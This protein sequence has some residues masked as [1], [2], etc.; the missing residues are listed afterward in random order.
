MAEAAGASLSVTPIEWNVVGLDS[1]TPATGPHAFSVGAQVCNTGSTTIPDVATTWVWDTSSTAISLTGA[2]V[3]PSV[4]LAPAACQ[5]FWYAVDVVALAS[6]FDKIRGFH[7]VA[8]GTGALSVSTPTPREIYV[9]HL[10]SQNRNAIT[11]VSG[12]TA[13]LVGNTYTYTVSG[14]TAPGGYGQLVASPFFDPSIF[15]VRSVSETMSVGGPSTTFYTDACGW[16]T[17]PTS[18]SYR[19]CTT[20]AD[21]GGTFTA[22][23]TATV[24]GTGTTTVRSVI[25]DFS[26]SSYHYN[27]DFGD[28]INAITVTATDPPVNG[29]PVA[30]DDSLTVAQDSLG[31]SVTVLGNDSDPDSDP[32][33]VSAVTQGG[34]GAVS[35]NLDGSVSYV[36]AAGYSGADSFTYTVSDGN[37]GF[38]TATVSVTVTPTPPPVPPTPTPTPTPAPAPT[39]SS[40]P[41]ADVEGSVAGNGPALAA[42]KTP[43]AV[44]RIR[45]SLPH[46]GATS[47]A[48]LAESALL[49][50]LVGSIVL[51][52]GTRRRVRGR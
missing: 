9:E 46:T 19:S 10:V 34:H 31:G 35:I 11:G 40:A 20:S 21:A 48:S 52:A 22:T 6:S 43:R 18:G 33:T 45:S 30:G 37:G 51:V 13:V 17:D 2:A 44:V 42:H 1:N 39:V 32:L 14:K 23:V 27:S 3:K 25:Y 47:S 4:S 36:P 26:G 8:S 28:A 49:L 41:A 29:D 12:P 50:L 7:V 24:V 15:E 16:V 38:D 5:K